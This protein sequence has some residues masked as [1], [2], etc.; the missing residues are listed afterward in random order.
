MSAVKAERI[1]SCV[2]E[3]LVGLYLRLNGYFLISNYLLHRAWTESHDGLRAEIDHLAVRF[4]YQREVLLDGWI[5]KNDEQLILPLDKSFV[6]F[7]I[8]EVKEPSVEFNE[9]IEGKQGQQN[10]CDVIEMLGFDEQ[11][12]ANVKACKIA[13]MLHGQVRAKSWQD[14]PTYEDAAQKVSIR[15]IV[16][17]R[18]KSKRSQERRFISLEHVLKVTRE[19]VSEGY[20]CRGYT[21]DERF[22][23]WRG[24]GKKLLFA[25]DEARAS[26]H[27]DLDEFIQHVMGLGVEG[28]C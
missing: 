22:S 5:Q 1:R 2:F 7:I 15:M 21:R 14:F 12:G 11:E 17:A 23:A 10:L 4:P 3:S 8:A 13:E 28:S 18:E 6:D 24:L 9:P 16:F 19:R 26:Q 20:A 27:R 25:L